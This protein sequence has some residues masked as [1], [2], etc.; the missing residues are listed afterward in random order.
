MQQSIQQVVREAEDNYLHGS[1]Q[2][3]EY[4]EFDLHDTIEKIDAYL[5]SRHISG[6][7]DSLGRDKPFFNICTAAANIWYRA[8]DIDRKDIR[9]MPDCQDNTALAFIATILLQQWM[10]DARFGVFLN[11]WGRTLARYGS[12]VTKFVERDGELVAEVVPWNRLIV[13]PIDFDA[14]PRIEKVWKTAEQLRQMEHYDREVVDALIDARTARET[15]DGKQ[16]DNQSKFIEVYEVHGMLPASLLTDE[17]VDDESDEVY[18]QQMHVVA[19]VQGK[20]DEFEDF[21]LYRGREAK[22]PY[23]ITHLIKEDGRTLSIG[24]VE[25]LFEAQW[26]VN[27]SQKNIKDTL[28]LAS[29]LIFQTSDGAYVG[30]NVLTAIETGQVMVHK[31]NE[32]LTRMANDKPDISALQNF[33]VQWQNL[34]QEITSTPDAM[35]GTTMPSGT[36]Y[37]L[38]AFLG[39]QANSL[40]ELMTENKGLSLEE[41]MR[42]HILPNLMKKMDTKDEVVALLDERGITEIDSMYVPREA[43]RRYNKEAK[44]ALI[45]G[46]IPPEFDQVQMQGQ[47]QQELGKMGNMRPF[48][49]SDIKNKTWKEAL[50][51]FEMRATVEVTNENTDKQAVLATLS[52]VLQ[53]IAANPMVLQD[54]NAKMVFSQ[55]LTETGKISPIQLSTAQ[56]SQPQ[57]LGAGNLQAL[58]ED[59]N[60]TTA[61]GAA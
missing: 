20:G 58:T 36:P 52:S 50:K 35:T 32:P 14:L 31:P 21:T 44:R 48:K 38:G 12:A 24:A 29:K 15:L 5:N 6:S 33:A 11:E 34:A 43:I 51:G 30:R 3:S 39:A 18:T 28:D 55:I 40:F 25:H 42:I 60:G 56:T 9:I 47:V 26:M 37:S 4:V 8:T 19:F 54:P 13:D 2:M 57:Q 1:V 23:M 53:T 61:T 46:Q 7:Q 59:Q 17:H 27:H 10:K 22:D 45:D 49:P 41:M 16:Q